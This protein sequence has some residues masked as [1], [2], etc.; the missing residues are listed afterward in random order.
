MNADVLQRAAAVVPPG[1]AACAPGPAAGASAEIA[2]Y[3]AA[4]VGSLMRAPAAV[5]RPEMNVADAIAVIRAIPPQT[6]FT[7]GFVVDDLGRAAGVLVMRMLLIADPAH[8]LADVMETPVFSLRPEMDF[9]EA[10]QATMTRHFP[11]YPVCDDAGR[12]LGVVRGQA[13]F[14][15][16]LVSLT[17]QAGEMVGVDSE[18]GPSTPFWR[19]L[20]FRFSWLQANLLTAF[21]AALVVGVFQDLI[22]RIVLLAIFLPVLAGQSGN[23]GAQSLAVTIRAMTLGLIDGKRVR[24]LMT[25]EV[26]LGALNGCAGGIV[27]GSVMYIVAALQ[28][29]PDAG[30]LSVVVFLAM[31]FSSV[32]SGLAGGSLPLILKRLGADPA[33][34]STIILTTATDIVSMG[35]MLTLAVLLV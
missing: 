5:F 4:K 18:D 16:E 11:E 3:P 23:T 8:C 7:Y 28:E 34:A 26:G 17:A 13:L 12:L 1:N 9:V 33:I 30:L 24:A 14:R 21:L 15:A 32:V 27:A 10:M 20:R 29:N 6:L 31:I 25:K 22:G 2:R 19:S 35:S